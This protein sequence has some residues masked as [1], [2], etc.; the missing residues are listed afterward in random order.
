MS[1]SNRRRREG[2]RTFEFALASNDIAGRST[3][4]AAVLN[5]VYDRT[6]SS[7]NDDANDSGDEPP[8]FNSRYFR[9]ALYRM[10]VDEE[11]ASDDTSDVSE[12]VTPMDPT[13]YRQHAISNGRPVANEEDRGI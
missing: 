10:R 2:G 1:S 13:T 8:N 6:H 4:N 11:E 12:D 3:L 7:E 5:V 9:R